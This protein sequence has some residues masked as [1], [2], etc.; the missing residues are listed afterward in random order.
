MREV[1]GN[2]VEIKID[3]FCPWPSPQHTF[4][5]KKKIVYVKREKDKFSSCFRKLVSLFCFLFEGE[6]Y[7]EE[8]KYN[9]FF[10]LKFL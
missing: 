5:N 2:H 6:R 4:I 8:L 7:E 1:L 9:A 10:M 3:T